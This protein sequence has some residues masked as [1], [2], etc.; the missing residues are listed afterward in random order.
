[1]PKPP[2]AFF[3]FFSTWR[4]YLEVGWMPQ[5]TKKSVAFVNARE[6]QNELQQLVVAN[7]S[8]TLRRAKHMRNM[9]HGWG[10][11]RWY[12]K[13]FIKRVFKFYKFLKDKKTQKRN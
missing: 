12:G 6:R 10:T 5:A 1:L 2:G 7:A 11:E 8:E 3:F 13:L 9:W 4:H